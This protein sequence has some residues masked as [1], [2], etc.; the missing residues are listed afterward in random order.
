MSEKSD[1]KKI[2]AKAFLLMFV[3]LKTIGQI[4]P[5]RWQNDNA[6]FNL[7]RNC[8]LAVSQSM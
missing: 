7:S 4:V 8:F 5:R 6:H 3:K 2:A 1:S